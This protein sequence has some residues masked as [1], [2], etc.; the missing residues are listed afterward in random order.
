MKIIFLI[1][2]IIGTGLNA[3]AQ[4]IPCTGED[5]NV[6]EETVATLDSWD[7][8]YNSYK[9][10]NQCDDG[11]LAEGYSDVI[12]KRLAYHW[13]QL[14]KLIKLKSEDENFWKFVIRH[15]DATTDDDDLRKI[16]SN[17][18]ISCQSKDICKTIEKRAKDA[19]EESIYFQNMPKQ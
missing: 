9:K 17:C 3:F 4:E 19:L 6:A 10:Y 7:D 15:I 12:V 16:I 2:I 11:A 1:L 5:A 14:D 18:E 13:E 8:I